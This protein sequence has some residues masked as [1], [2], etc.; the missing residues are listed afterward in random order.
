M[1]TS[2]APRTILCQPQ[3]HHTAPRYPQA[4]PYG[5]HVPFGARPVRQAFLTDQ[6]STGGHAAR[7][8]QPSA[9]HNGSLGGSFKRLATLQSTGARCKIVRH[10]DVGPVVSGPDD[11][12][13]RRMFDI[14]VGMSFEMDTSSVH[15]VARIKLMDL[16]SIKLVP[17]PVLKLQKTWDLKL[18]GLALR[19]VYEVPVD[20]ID[21]PWAPPA[22]VMLRYVLLD[23]VVGIDHECTHRLDNVG[24][25]GLRFT[26]SGLEFDRTIHARS[27]GGVH[28]LLR[29]AGGLRF[30]RQYPVQPGTQLLDV[31]VRNL[32]LKTQW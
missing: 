31:Y 3:N 19:A 8:T 7:R 29:A 5:R 11:A 20:S 14:G 25:H 17:Q 23:L 18:H 9:W 32:G 1:S 13:Q 4:A 26:D 12:F 21:T 6:H 2:S 22:R 10:L 30:P 16:C 24:G 27:K 28:T 15:P